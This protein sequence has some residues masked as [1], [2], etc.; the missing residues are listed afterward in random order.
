M[1]IS[2]LTTDELEQLISDA[3][4]QIEQLRIEAR[5]TQSERTD[6]ITAAIDTLDALL[7]EEGAEPGV[8]SIRAVRGYTGEV[9]AEHAAVALPLA[10]HGLEIL[11]TVVR[12]IAATIAHEQ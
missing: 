1:D 5:D 12:D 8:D 11:T 2:E 9:M 6:R 7:G 3:Y 4:L 10:F